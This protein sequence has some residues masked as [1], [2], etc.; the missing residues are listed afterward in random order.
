VLA[1]DGESLRAIFGAPND[2]KF[3][4]LMTLF[5]RASDDNAAPSGGRLTVAAVDPI[6]LE[7]GAFGEAFLA[8]RPN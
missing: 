4:S 3:R 5:T 2:L 8:A 6:R 7:P 1:I